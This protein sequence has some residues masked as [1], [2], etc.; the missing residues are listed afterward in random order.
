MGSLLFYSPQRQSFLFSHMPSATKMKGLIKSA[1]LLAII[2]ICLFGVV[3]NSQSS[4]FREFQAALLSVQWMLLVCIAIWCGSFIFLAFS[5]K[6]LPLISLLF[7]VITAYLIGHVESSR[8]ADAIILLAGVTFGK[9]ACVLLNESALTENAG[10]GQSRL[11]SADTF[12]IGI[13][14][15]L[16]FSSWWHLDVAHNFYPGTRWTGLWDNPN[17]YGMLMGAGAT[18]AIGLLA[19]KERKGHKDTNSSPYPFP[20]ST[21]R[22]WNFLHSLSSLAAGLCRRRGNES[23]IENQKSEIG[24]E[25]S[26]RDSLRRLLPIFLFIAAGMMAV[27]LFF[28]Y[29]RGAWLGTAVGL[30]YLAKAYGKFKWRYVVLGVGCV[31]LGAGLLWG[32]TADDA[33]WYMKRMDFGRPSAQ[34]RVAAWKAGFEMMR[35]H[36]FGV[37]WN[38]AVS[39]YDKNYS[40][41]ENGAA[42]LTMNSYLMLGTELG[43]PGL[44]CFVAYSYLS[45]RGRGRHSVRAVGGQGTARPT[46]Q[47]ACRAGALMLLVAFWF[48]GGLFTLATASVFWILLDLG[49]VSNVEGKMKNAETEQSS[50]VVAA[51]RP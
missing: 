37:G 32:R 50:Q 49:S 4:I 27:G 47:T 1:L 12:L 35:D 28:S 16:A 7:I 11:T 19:T 10:F 40:P 42:A 18:L 14:L 31:A 44:I 46:I 15:L 23:Q 8:A 38:Q 43:L 51:P 39:V 36:P 6:D 13:V 34:H 9:G 2:S 33:P 17:D 30:L 5:L 48:D 29:S 26:I 20:R 3:L 22:M 21:K 41:P 45:F 24:N 25:K